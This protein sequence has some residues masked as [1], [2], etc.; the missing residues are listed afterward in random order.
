MFSLLNQLIWREIS[1]PLLFSLFTLTAL[2]LLGRLIPLLEPL[3]GSGITLGEFGR[4]I[5]LI[6]P[7]L[8]LVVVPVSCMMGILLAFMRLSRDGEMLALFACGIGPRQMAMPV[9][10]VCL[11]AW[12]LSLAT[13]TRWLPESK[14]KSK[15]FIAE[16]MQKALA[17]GIPEQVFLTPVDGLTIYCNKTS[18]G[19]KRL[20]GVYIKDSRRQELSYQILARRGDIVAGPRGRQVV[21]K[22]RDGTLTRIG[23]DFTRMDLLRFDSYMLHL[24]LALHEPGRGRGEMGL[25]ELLKQARA[26]GNSNSRTWRYLTEFHKRLA[27][28][29]GTFVLGMLAAP[30][31]IL[32]GRAGLSGGVAIG[33]GTFLAY[34]LLIIFGGNLAESGVVP[35]TALW[36][37]NLLFG[38]MALWLWR[39]LSRRGPIQG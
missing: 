27:I 6:V 29:V 9:A 32:F 38:I 21:L 26:P 31:G 24:D 4:L 8:L 13:S 7:T 17:K 3:L 18:R 36:F 37:P 15:V 14:A 11:A 25:G 28:P 16:V 35:A 1:V 20:K 39:L 22:L 2:L 30:L 23:G 5:V 10:I 19:G 12:G 34:Y 33:L